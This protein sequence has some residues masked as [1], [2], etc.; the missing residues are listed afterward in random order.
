MKAAFET[1][2]HEAEIPPP[3]IEDLDLREAV[4][5]EL[6]RILASRFFRSAGRSRQFL[7]Y[8]VRHKLEGHLELLKERTIGTEVFH[9]PHGYATGDDPVVR[10]QAGEVRRRLEQ[11][12]QAVEDCPIVSIELPLGAYAPNFRWRTPVAGP[13]PLPMKVESPA[14]AQSPA[15]VLPPPA[16]PP[17]PKE[18]AHVGRWVAFG[19]CLCLGLALAFVTGTKSAGLRPASHVDSILQQ[20]WSP[21]FA[22]QQPVFIC[23]AQPV[24]YRPSLALYQKYA[25]SHP[26]TFQS[27]VER[28]N[29]PLPLSPDERISWREM[30]LYKEYGVTIGD[31]YAAVSLSGLLG[32]IGKPGQVRIGSSYS[33]TDLRNSPSVLV[34]AFNNRWT[35]QLTSSLHYAF[36]ESGGHLMIREQVPS[37]P[38][39]GERES[40]DGPVSEDYALV[41]RL[42]DSKTGQFTLTVAGLDGKGTQA[43][44]EF[45]TNS[46]LLE[47]GLH[48][49]PKDWQKGNVELLLQSTIT[50]SIA[51]P[52]HVVAAYFW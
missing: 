42:L 9:R 39:W 10:V 24:S 12:Y 7:E 52:P 5:Q 34:G 2:N 19:L 49:A 36:V 8:V 44:A 41:A 21:V 43:A 29:V 38:S 11:Y 13:V 17:A 48:N 40:P 51:G 27:E 4:H 35:M 22:T 45:V 1:P 23:L 6:S 16:A 50:D 31:T 25:R 33:F 14:S 37:G 3:A 32:K 30:T 26:G 46:E 28:S 47:K 18:G 15:I 20:F